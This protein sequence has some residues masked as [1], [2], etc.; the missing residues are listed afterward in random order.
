MSATHAK[1]L[2]VDDE[3]NILLALQRLTRT[4]GLD[5]DITDSPEKACRLIQET[6]Y[7]VVVSDHRM[8]GLTGTELL[9]KVR[10]CSPD[11]VRIL[12]TGHA[13]VA[14]AI[15]AIN[16]GAVYRFVSKPWQNDDLWLTL[17]QAIEQHAL[18]QENKRLQQSI[19]E[20]NA[21]LQSLN[22]SL[23]IKVIERTREIVSLNQ[24]LETSLLRSIQV[25]SRISEMHSSLIGSH[26]RR[27][28]LLC[29]ALAQRMGLDEKTIRQLHVAALLHDIGKVALPAE[30]LHK[31]EQALQKTDLEKHRQHAE[32]GENWL[33]LIPDLDEA[34][35]WVRHHHEW[36]N[37]NGYPDKL[38]GESI[39]LEAR[40]IA[41]A[42]CYDN[43][44]NNPRSLASTNVSQALRALEG[45]AG[46]QLDP[47]IVELFIRHVQTES[48]TLDEDATEIEIY[49]KDLRAGMVLSRDL[50]S[51]QGVLLLP[52]NTLI[53]EA[54]LPPL[55]K[56]LSAIPDFREIYI[57]RKSTTGM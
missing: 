7:A 46:K 5:I 3:M 49:M 16:Q 25:L 44:L 15:K 32:Y 43:I 23:E 31:P 33:K 21:E 53:D 55:R 52:K 42:D 47:A 13:D 34:A 37:G 29:D 24:K 41:V 8:P 39:P 1:V 28:A 51:G 35:L 26:A 22:Q 36:F 14:A 4:K 6:P 40:L 12:L 54:R 56:L 30:V 2:F 18:I 57:Y 45:L 27:V 17:Q 19:R 10:E 9:S 48:A 38:F 50:V 11:T 20:K